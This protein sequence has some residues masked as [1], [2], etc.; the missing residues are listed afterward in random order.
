MK[1]II[2]LNI[3]AGFFLTGSAQ[4]GQQYFDAVLT[5]EDSYHNFESVVQ[6]DTVDYVFE[7][8]YKGDRPLVISNVLTSCGCTASE[9]PRSHISPGS[10][11]I[12]KVT[13]NSNGKFGHQRKIIT[14]LSNASNNRIELIIE[15]FVL[16]KRSQF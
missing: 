7:F 2:A 3:F 13:F 15:A 12:I 1:R 10:K 4:D 8:T 9:W 6:G 11:G 14:V 5:F 16:P